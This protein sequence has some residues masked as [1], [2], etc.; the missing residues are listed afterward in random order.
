[1]VYFLNTKFD[2]N[3]TNQ[4]ISCLFTFRNNSHVFPCKYRNINYNYYL[5]I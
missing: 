3:V 2:K 1:M 5:L 4:K